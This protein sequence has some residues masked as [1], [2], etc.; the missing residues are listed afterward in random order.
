MLEGKAAI[1]SFKNT[2]KFDVTASLTPSCRPRIANLFR[3]QLVSLCPLETSVCNEEHVLRVCH[4]P[5]CS[6]GST[7]FPCN[8]ERVFFMHRIRATTRGL[9]LFI[10]YISGFKFAQYGTHLDNIS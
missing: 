10:P 5:F 4:C 9:T 1:P 7:I 3:L 2:P 6:M 8:R